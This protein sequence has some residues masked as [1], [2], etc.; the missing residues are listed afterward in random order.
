MQ[1]TENVQSD[2][3]SPESRQIESPYHMPSLIGL[4]VREALQKMANR[5]MFVEVMGNGVVF[6]QE[7]G[8]GVKVENNKRC[9]LY[10]REID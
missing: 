4:S 3:Q 10:C 8:Y 9:R 6:K 2:S 1:I 7:P 5:D